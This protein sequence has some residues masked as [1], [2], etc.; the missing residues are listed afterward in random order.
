MDAHF[1][2]TGSSKNPKRQNADAAGVRFR[3]N[4]LHPRSPSGG[5]PPSDNG[6]AGTGRLLRQRLRIEAFQQRWENIKEDLPPQLSRSHSESV[7]FLPIA[8][9]L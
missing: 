6:R 1:A 5:A 7:L 8:L 3:L 2:S 9:G 4:N